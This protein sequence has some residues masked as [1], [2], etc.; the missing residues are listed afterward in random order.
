MVVNIIGKSQGK[1]MFNA[2]A[3]EIELERMVS[4][5]SGQ[6]A[7]RR[8]YLNEGLEVVGTGAS[9]LF[10][11]KEHSRQQS[12][13]STNPLFQRKHSGQIKIHLMNN[14]TLIFFLRV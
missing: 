14:V 1:G 5:W 12:R 3:W 11:E 4:G 10:W 8:F 7:P 9:W 13:A 6:D 2:V